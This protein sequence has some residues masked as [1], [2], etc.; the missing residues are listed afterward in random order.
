MSGFDISVEDKTETDYKIKPN[1]AENLVDAIRSD[2]VGN[3]EPHLLMHAAYA[4]GLSPVVSTYNA[5]EVGGPSGAGK[6]ALK[7]SVDRR[8]PNHWLLSIT[9]TSEKGMIDDERW[10]NR[11]VI[12]ADEFQKLPSSA[13]EILKSTFSDDADEDGWGYRYVRNTSQQNG[14]DHREIK[15]QVAPFSTLIADENEARGADTELGTRTMTIRVE[16]NEELN[17]AVS[18]TFW[19]HEEVTL[20][21]TDFEYNYK[22]EDGKSVIDKHI[23]SIPRFEYR[24]QNVPDGWATNQ[25]YSYPV[26][27]PN[28]DSKKWPTTNGRKEWDAHKV[29]KPMF[30]FKQTESKRASKTVANLV[31]GWAR[32]NHHSREVI[33]LDG[34][35]WL[36]ADPQ[37]VGN[38]IAC[39]ETLLSLTHNF[40]ER[41]MAVIRAL[42][43][44]K[45]GVGGAGPTGGVAAPIQDIHEYLEEYAEITSVSE[46]H[47]RTTVLGDMIDRFLLTIHENETEN[48]A[49]LYEYH[50]GSTF[51]HPNVD[52]YPDIFDNVT[53]PIRDQPIR[54]TIEE[55]K[56]RLDTRT[57]SGVFSGSGSLDTAMGDDGE[58]TESASDDDSGLSAFGGGVDEEDDVELTETEQHVRE[59][60]Q[61]VVDDCRITLSDKDDLK[62]SHMVGATPVEYYTSDEGFQ[63]VRPERPPKDGDKDGTI[64]DTDHA[65]WGANVDSGKVQAQVE[66]AVGSLVEKGIFEN[67]EED[68]NVEYL[69]VR[70][71]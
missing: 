40:N 70:D 52:E 37:D 5:V 20:P 8:W 57:S 22:F 34:H 62:V 43:D 4:T 23:A 27:I 54:D 11:Y 65:N 49:H 32:L 17:E 51:G 39:R 13:L 61:S 29:V 9:N 36:V 12:A 33:N 21:D 68:G 63:Y 47:L 1:F 16:D 15:K 55:M 30:S 10:N 7:E 60:L 28:S 50:G 3:E 25:K 48:G 69:L 66:A 19:G 46:S 24:Q 45:N 35:E 26:I 38:V 44:P 18:A 71:E 64:L 31:R 6:S 67:Y 58:D 41:K 53:D 59:A 2:M 14:D 42:T 56:Q